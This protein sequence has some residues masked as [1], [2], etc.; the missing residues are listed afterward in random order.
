MK[1]KSKLYKVY[2]NNG[3]KIRVYEKILNMTNNVITE[4]SNSKKKN[5]NNLAKKLKEP[6]LNWKAYWGILSIL[7][8][9]KNSN[10]SSS[11][12]KRLKKTKN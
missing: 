2:I 8:T 4:I 3:R 11:I 7:T 12:H 9:R 5:F 6:K 1:G 10:Y